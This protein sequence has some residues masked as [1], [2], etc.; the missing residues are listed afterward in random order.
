MENLSTEIER[1]FE[2]CLLESLP[3]AMIDAA[4]SKYMAEPEANEEDL[5]RL[6]IV[7]L[8][9]RNVAAADQIEET[10][11]LLALIKQHPSVEFDAWSDFFRARLALE[12]TDDENVLLLLRKVLSNTHPIVRRLHVAA[13]YYLASFYY[14][15]GV[16]DKAMEWYQECVLLCRDQNNN[17]FLAN[18]IL[19][20]AE[21][22]NLKGAFAIALELIEEAI[23]LTKTAHTP[24]GSQN[25]IIAKCTT[26]LE[27][28]RIDEVI[29]L[30]VPLRE[31][32]VGSGQTVHLASIELILAKALRSKQKFAD[33]RRHA[34][35][36]VA[37]YRATNR[38]YLLSHSLL[39]LSD[40]LIAVGSYEEASGLIEEARRIS[41]R[42]PNS[43]LISSIHELTIAVLKA[44]GRY[45]EALETYQAFF[46]ARQR[47]VSEEAERRMALLRIEHDVRQK[48]QAIEVY[49]LKSEKLETEL[50]TKTGHLV[51]QAEM[52]S[53][54]AGD[55]RKILSEV[56]DPVAG[57]RKVRE[58]L[59]ELSDGSM[60]WEEY[61][62]TFA[63]VHPE[64]KHHL[65]S[66]FPT[67]TPMELKVC[68]LLRIELTSKEIANLLNISE[69]SV[70]NHRYRAR[71]KIGLGESEN[72]YQFLSAI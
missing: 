47:M 28:G 57:L 36:A 25:L 46:E 58:K 2:V 42:I 24:K 35:A 29:E 6:K 15:Q 13:S 56:S 53:S 37:D 49:R 8:V 45:E 62:K 55:M 5:I 3:R 17:F 54:F 65:L 63:A 1:M 61:D 20:L 39:Q 67:L 10:E 41:E 26:L 16:T 23:E 22:N 40:L 21:I 43:Y 60:D 18:T 71:K 52:L 11:S 7:T 33:A 59:R 66:E 64:F 32:V 50:M 34:E 51:R 68:T 69:R 44:Q 48:E 38:H 31:E 72:F 70:E 9:H 30:M 4:L 19:R 12:K 14:Q 27:L